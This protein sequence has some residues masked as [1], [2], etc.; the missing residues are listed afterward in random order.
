MKMV[1]KGQLARRITPAFTLG[2]ILVLAVQIDGGQSKAAGA[3][4]KVL[5]PTTQDNLTIFPIVTGS[6]PNTHFFLTLDEGI[7]SGEVVIT[8]QGGSPGLIRPHPRRPDTVRP[9]QELSFPQRGPGRGAEVNQ[10]MLINNSDRPLILLAGEI[11]MG[12]KQDRVVGKDRII[13]AKSDPIDLSVFCVEPHRWVETSARFGGAFSAMAQPSVRH[14]AMAA[15]D[16]QAVWNEVA[17]SRASIAAEVPYVA[18]RSLNGTSSYAVTMENGAV[19]QRVDAVAAPFERSY[20]KLM[21]E[22]RAQKAVGLWS[23]STV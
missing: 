13:P 19:R 16:Q 21:G 5:P 20:E 4:Y 17:K 22:L 10:L 15:K 14:Q 3:S 8:E 2:A 18:A 6:T 23:R 1:N 11:V 7:R 9:M 12:G